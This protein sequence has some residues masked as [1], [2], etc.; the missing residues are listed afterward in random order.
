MKFFKS[1]DYERKN[2][3]ESELNRKSLEKLFRA[4]E[5]GNYTYAY[6]EEL[7]IFDAIKSGNLKLAD[8]IM[9]ESYSESYLKQRF[10]SIRNL[11]NFCIVSVTLISRAA[12]EGGLTEDIGFALSESYIEIIEDC[13][14]ED[15]IIFIFQFCIYDF[16]NRVADCQ[17]NRYSQAIN[18]SINYIQ[19]HIHEKISTND[20]TKITGLSTRQLARKFKSELSQSIVEYIQYEKIEAAKKLLEFSTYSILEIGYFLDFCSQSYFIDIFKKYEGVTPAHYR[21]LKV[22]NVK[23]E[24]IL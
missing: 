2:I 5:N 7:R 21:N 19:R 22:R 10:N 1:K 8:T 14:R 15:S 20:L 23:E 9:R 4:R 12:M 24:E 3:L 11:K 13:S 16:T 17:K 18:T 6:K